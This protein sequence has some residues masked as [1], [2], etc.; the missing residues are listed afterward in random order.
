MHVM[1]DIVWDL[2]FE[3]ESCIVWIQIV[4]NGPN[5]FTLEE[6]SDS[7]FPPGAETFFIEKV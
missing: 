4:E 2:S 3:V 7:F 1:S 5:S 6:A